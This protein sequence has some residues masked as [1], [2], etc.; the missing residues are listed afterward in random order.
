[1][2]YSG[3]AWG[4]HFPQDLSYIHPVFL[5]LGYL[6]IAK[7]MVDFYFS[8]IEQQRSNTRRIYGKPGVLWA[9]E[10]PI[11]TADDLL[12]EGTPNAFQYE[13]HN[14]AYPAR[15]AY[16]TA[17]SLRDVQWSRDCAWPVLFE[18]AL[19]LASCMSRGDDG[20]WGIHVVPS[21]GQDEY[22]GENAHDYLCALFAA[23]YTLRA[24]AGMA[25][26]LGI[27][28]EEVSRWTNILLEGI[29]YRR[30]VER[31]GFYRSNADTRFVTGKQKHPVQL[32]PLTFLPLGTVD[33]PTHIAWKLRHRICSVQREGVP[34][35]GVPGTFYEGWTLFAFLLAAARMQD[36][37]GFAHELK[38]MIASQSVDPDC[39]TIYESSGYWMPYYTT[40]M[41][42]FLQ[43]LMALQ[44]GP[45]EWLKRAPPSIE[46]L[47]SKTG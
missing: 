29:A 26:D 40:S 20:C 46:T 42:L 6:D 36:R 31:E 10:F 9:W 15:M 7:A 3:N 25:G 39:I 22:G 11:G 12:L 4:R 37:E 34:H 13:I 45:E 19:F 5:K 2:G 32:N 41:G 44:E 28:N 18:S 43:A 23:E 1:M 33:E 35:A 24:A 17:Q 14:A 27:E 47:M 8:R 30:L 21:M 16:E 38:Q